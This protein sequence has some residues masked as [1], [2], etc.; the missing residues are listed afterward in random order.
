M[1]M[2][3]VDELFGVDSLDLLL[4]RDVDIA[5]GF[6]GIHGGGGINR[7]EMLGK[8]NE[9]PAGSLCEGTLPRSLRACM[10][11]LYTSR[12]WLRVGLYCS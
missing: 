6:K 10:A 1:F 5:F 4:S 12:R 11:L 3:F 9:R 7:Q 8:S 2:S